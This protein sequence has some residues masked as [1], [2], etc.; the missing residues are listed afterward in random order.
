MKIVHTIG[1]VALAVIGSTTS[2]FAQGCCGGMGSMAMP[3][4]SS[5]VTNSAATVN[6]TLSPALQI[7][8]D[9]YIKLQANLAKDSIE[10][11]KDT[12]SAMVKAIGDEKGLSTN[13]AQ[14]ASA[15]AA[16]QDIDS[17]REALKPLSKSLIEYLKAQNAIA[18]KYK[19]AY[20]PMAKASWIQTEEEITNPY[21]GKSMLHCGQFKS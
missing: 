9:N 20:C 13:T 7:V 4:P 6:P 3:S 18:G 5:K 1:I 19:E 21:M 17:A 16:A 8:V 11:L 14:Q 15:L 10:G 12:A 2:V